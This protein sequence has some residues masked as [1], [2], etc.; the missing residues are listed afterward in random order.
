MRKYLPSLIVLLLLTS[1]A[2]GTVM[3]N[4]KVA[5]SDFQSPDNCQMC[6]DQL[7]DQWNGSMHA[8]AWE[9]PV[10]QTLLAKGSVA[11]DGLI[12]DFCTKCH[13][14]IGVLS[15]ENL[16]IDGSNYSAVSQEAIQCDF[17]HTVTDSTAQGNSSYTFGP[18]NV[19]KGPF[20]DARPFSHKATYSAIH[21][22]AEFCG[23]CH[24]VFHPVNGLP[25]ELTYTEWKNS[26]YAAEGI[27]C[28]D[29][30]MTPGPGVTKPNPGQAASMGPD[31]EHIWTHQFVGANFAVTEALGFTDHAQAARERLQSAAQLQVTA[32]NWR[33]GQEN[34]LVVSVENIGAG[35]YLP[36]GLTE[37]RQLWLEVTLRTPTGQ[38]VY[39]SG[40]LDDQLAIDQAAVV[41]NTVIADAQGNP[42]P[43]VW[44]AASII[45]DYR[46][47]PRGTRTETYP[48]SVPAGVNKLMAEV[49]LRYR[50]APQSLIDELLGA[51][52]FALPIFDLQTV[53][54][55]IMVK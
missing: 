55:E 33:A 39:Q 48:V 29:C 43:Y 8:L 42:T 14:P 44:E 16:P 36:T 52:S 35:H 50:S 23:A 2:V 54:M 17:C 32:D 51:E 38:V 47:P 40:H 13:V 1:V 11:T 6:H 15:G 34:K 31:R 37:A 12:D 19:K 49:R 45:R 41:Y 7:F 4:T 28:Q 21:T 3:A 20:A 26:P 9:D 10:F 25:L 53:N 30:H 22:Q 24:D 27:V 5:S 18:S 46:I